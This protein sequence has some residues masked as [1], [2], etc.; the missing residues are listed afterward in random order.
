VLSRQQFL[1]YTA[2]QASVV[3]VPRPPRKL[4]LSQRVLAG[5]LW[6]WLIPFLLLG[7]LLLG[8]L[9]RLKS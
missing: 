9:P 8:E 7:F 2:S 1:R 3:S 5:V 6:L 4:T